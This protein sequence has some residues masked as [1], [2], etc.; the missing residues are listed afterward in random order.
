MWNQLVRQPPLSFFSNGVGVGGGEAEMNRQSSVA[1]QTL[2]CV[3]SIA[4]L[5]GICCTA[6]G[7]QPGAP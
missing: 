6:Q 3:R 5:G 2:L 1:I 7:A 4:Q